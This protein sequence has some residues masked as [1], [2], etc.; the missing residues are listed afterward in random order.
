MIEKPTTIR[1]VQ[2]EDLKQIS[3]L[4]ESQFR[5]HFLGQYSTEVIERFYSSFLG[6]SIFLVSGEDHVTGF[7]LGG[8]SLKLVSAKSD[9]IKT[10][11]WLIARETVTRPLLYRQALNH[12]I[13]ALGTKTSSE[14]DPECVDLLSIAVENS[15][16]GTGLAADLLKAFEAALGPA[17]EYHTAVRKTN[18]RSLKFFEK[19]GTLVE[20]EAQGVI[21]LKIELK[22]SYASGIR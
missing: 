6:K 3:L 22:A 14:A 1:P 17:T 2:T 4:H 11:K 16:K 20:R 10:N 9:F 13:D 7:V 19:R 5:D 15:K 12:V 21:Y 8:N 18:I